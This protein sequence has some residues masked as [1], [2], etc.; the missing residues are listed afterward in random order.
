MRKYY[1]LRIQ[2]KFLEDFTEKRLLGFPLLFV[3]VTILTLL[4]VIYLAGLIANSS[5][6]YRV[7]TYHHAQLA[8]SS[9][10]DFPDDTLLEHKAWEHVALLLCPLH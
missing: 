8:G 2:S 10:L 6:Q 4:V 5:Y 9:T 7:D 1:Y 3:S